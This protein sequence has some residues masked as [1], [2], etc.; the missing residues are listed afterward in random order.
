[1]DRRLPPPLLR[2]I[3]VVVVVVVGLLRAG[4][5]FLLVVVAAAATAA[6]AVEGTSLQPPFMRM[7]GVRGRIHTHTHIIMG[8]HTRRRLGG[9]V[10][11]KCCKCVCVCVCV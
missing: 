2:H 6:A 9:S 10:G 3:L 11:R 7:K 8:P 5:G 4:R 1:M